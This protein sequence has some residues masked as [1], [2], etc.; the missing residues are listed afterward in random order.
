MFLITVPTFLEIFFIKASWTPFL[1]VTVKELQVRTESLLEYF[2]GR[3]EQPNIKRMK[4]EW[5]VQVGRLETERRR[6]TTTWL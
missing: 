6:G 2:W 1:L 3:E 4:D 5:S